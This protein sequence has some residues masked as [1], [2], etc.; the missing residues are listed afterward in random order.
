MSTAL[1]TVPTVRARLLPG[2]M[3][4]DQ[5]ISMFT[6]ECI[7][8]RTA[9]EAI[10][11]WQD[12]RSRAA[13]LP[14]GRGAACARL[15]LN[16]EE[17]A[18]A[19]RFIDFLNLQTNG[20]HPVA[21]VLKVDIGQM[22]VHQYRVVTERSEAYAR[23]CQTETAWLNEFLPTVIQP[24]QLGIQFS[25][26]PPLN[27]HPMSSRITI[28]LPHSEFAFLPVGQRGMFAP[29]QFMRYVTACEHGTKIMLKAGYH[30]SFAR[31]T[32]AP[33]ATV[34]AAVVAVERNTW[35]VPVNQ[36]PTG[37]GVTVGVG[38]LHFSGLLPALFSDF[39]TEGL[40]MDVLLRRKRF[41]L[42]SSIDLDGVG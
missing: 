10:A 38:E 3:T 30:R 4:R 17:Q 22:I 42:Q 34:P 29:N 39:F 12:Y 13:G 27:P 5:A 20:Q 16:T 21:E 8:S 19:R 23:N 28:D 1:V 26:G 35:V 37:V 32:S 15:P 41:Q 18:H 6:T 14:L 25:L 36:P 24:V 9:E 31:F 11:T 7:P 2:W 33:P 40:F